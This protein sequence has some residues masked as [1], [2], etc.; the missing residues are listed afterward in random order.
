MTLARSILL[1]T[2]SLL[3]TF[4]PRAAHA[5]CAEGNAGLTVTVDGSNVTILPT[6]TRHC[7]D[8]NVL[9][10][11]DEATGDVVALAA[12]CGSGDNAA[13]FV[14]RCVAKGKYRYGYESPFTCGEAGGCS[15]TVYLFDE[16][17]VVTS[18]ASTCD[19]G[20]ASCASTP[21]TA[22]LPWNMNEATGTAE[23]TTQCNDGG[24]QISAGHEPHVMMLDAIAIGLGLALMARKARS[25]LRRDR[26]AP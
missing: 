15:G 9:L 13:A 18:L 21:S 5:D 10:R 20:E 2:C 12:C 16:A 17:D 4:V 24:C 22:A 1:A 7:G 14:D 3:I 8:S 25:T 6:D 26:S 19:A 11:Q 23:Q